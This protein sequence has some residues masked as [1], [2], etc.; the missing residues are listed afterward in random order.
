MDSPLVFAIQLSNSFSLFYS[1]TS[2][3]RIDTVPVSIFY[4]NQ[5]KFTQLVATLVDDELPLDI[6]SCN[7]MGETRSGL[8]LA[9]VSIFCRVVAGT[10][11]DPGSFVEV[12]K[13]LLLRPK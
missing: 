3:P 7:G 12:K 10:E 11:T 5:N 2:G 4:R 13:M 1:R 9:A 8:R 6:T